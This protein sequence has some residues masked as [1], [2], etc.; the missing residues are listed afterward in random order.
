MP[1]NCT[2]QSI[3]L[4]ELS[5]ID[6][7]MKTAILLNGYQICMRVRTLKVVNKSEDIHWVVREVCCDL[8]NKCKS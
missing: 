1:H 8:S 5:H 3:S 6:P 4:K 7:I 2:I